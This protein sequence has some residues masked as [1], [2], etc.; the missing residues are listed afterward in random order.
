MALV[1]GLA[2]L[3]PV[4]GAGHE[5]GL[6][7]LGQHMLAVIQPGPGLGRGPDGQAGAGRQAQANVGVLARGGQ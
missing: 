6:H 5:H 7:I 1:M 4:G 2:W 3:Q